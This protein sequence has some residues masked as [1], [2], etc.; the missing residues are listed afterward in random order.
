[1]I[2]P[3]L[4]KYDL[5]EQMIASIDYPINELLIIDN[6][7][8]AGE[9]QNDNIGKIRVL[10]L[11]SN[12]GVPASWNLGIKLYPFSPYWVIS[13]NDVVFEKKTLEILAKALDPDRK[14]VV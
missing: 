14:S 2:I 3:V 9:Y 7:S 10:Q 4:N 12:L 11:P 5:L 8:G 1:M 6:G 13:S